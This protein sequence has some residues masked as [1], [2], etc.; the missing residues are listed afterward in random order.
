MFQIDFSEQSAIGDLVEMHDGDNRES[1]QRIAKHFPQFNIEQYMIEHAP[2]SENIM[3]K[4]GAGTGKT[5]VM[6]DSCAF[7]LDSYIE[8]DTIYQYNLI[9]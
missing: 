9:Y 1:V 7:L 3:V 5:T 6:I 8:N 4:A 2:F